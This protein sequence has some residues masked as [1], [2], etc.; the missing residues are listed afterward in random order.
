MY[1]GNA[2]CKKIT[3]KLTKTLCFKSEL[4]GKTISPVHISPPVNIEETASQ[5][6]IVLAVPGH[7]RE[8][9]SL[10][11]LDGILFISAKKEKE[12]YTP[13]D[14][15]EYDYADWTRT[16]SL[17]GDSDVMLTHAKYW[18]GELIIGIPRGNT[19]ENKAKAI[20]YVY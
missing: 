9:F 4:G 7:H 14:R 6:L 20:V 17:P 11:I 5:Y 12:S 2:T 3:P 16:F 8:D 1:P 15:W 19:D 10:E 13:N 18:N